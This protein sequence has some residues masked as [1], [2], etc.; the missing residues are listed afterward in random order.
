MSI[1]RLGLFGFA[2]SLAFAAPTVAGASPAT[3]ALGV[4]Q[5]F[6][7]AFNKGDAKGEA[8]LCASPASILDDFAPHVWQGATACADWA[9]SYA[10]SAKQNHV[11]G[12]MVTLAKPWHADVTGSRA[13]LVVPTTFAYT[14]HGKRVV[15]TGN[16][17]TL[18]LVKTSAG[19]RIAAWAWGDGP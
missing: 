12:G 13:Y 11:T 6:T 7:A 14:D 19:W 4:V 15:H 3:D 2:C 10:A 5:Q 8:A 16:V 17:W 18:A 1:R 9:S